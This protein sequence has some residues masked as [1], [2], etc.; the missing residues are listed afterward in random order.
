MTIGYNAKILGVAGHLGDDVD[1]SCE[2][3]EFMA[4]RYCQILQPDCDV[5]MYVDDDLETIIVTVYPSADDRANPDSLA[6][7]HVKATRDAIW[8][9]LWDA[10]GPYG[11]Y[12][13][14][15]D[16]TAR[17]ALMASTKV[18]A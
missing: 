10:I 12:R 2:A 4:H 18:V 17:C 8:S 6:W 7:K 14:P 1:A 9:R 16:L 13:L 11:H 3:F 15:A 5:C